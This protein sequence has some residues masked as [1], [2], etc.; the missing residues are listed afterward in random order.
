MEPAGFLVIGHEMEYYNDAICG[1]TETH[2][3][4][5][6]IFRLLTL[7]PSQIYVSCYSIDRRFHE[8]DTA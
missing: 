5:R 4:V 7:F 6:H 3:P 2:K 1:P 8:E